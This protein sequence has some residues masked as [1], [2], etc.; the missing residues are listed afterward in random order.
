L[1]HVNDDEHIISDPLNECGST[2]TIRR[3]SFDNWQGGAVHFEAWCTD[4]PGQGHPV[5]DAIKAKVA[6]LNAEHGK[7]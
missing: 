3:R 4:H 6:E 1:T 5:P 2:V 7:G